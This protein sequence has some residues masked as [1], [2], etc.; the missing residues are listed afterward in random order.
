M[1]LF[2][3]GLGGPVQERQWKHYVEGKG[4]QKWVFVSFSFRDLQGHAGKKDLE[5]RQEVR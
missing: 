5:A 2:V 3:I 4:M 1:G